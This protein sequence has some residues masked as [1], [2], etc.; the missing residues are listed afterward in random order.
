[1]LVTLIL[2]SLAPPEIDPAWSQ[3]LL[4]EAGFSPDGAGA[5]AYLQT[6]VS[7]GDKQARVRAFVAQL[8]DDNFDRREEAS[9]QLRLAGPAALAEIRRAVDSTDAEVRR[10]AR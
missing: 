1:M 3:Q 7:E 4:R 2:L 10:R 9:R 6:W 8:G 5:L